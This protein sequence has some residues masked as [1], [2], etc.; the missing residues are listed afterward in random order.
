MKCFKCTSENPKGSIFCNQ[1][2]YRFRYKI[3]N[4]P[5]CSN[6]NYFPENQYCTCPDCKGLLSFVKMQT[7]DTPIEMVFVEGGSLEMGEV[8]FKNAPMEFKNA[9]VGSF[10][11]AKYLTTQALWRSVMGVNPSPIGN[12][13]NCPVTNVSWFDCVLFC[14]ALSK[15]YRLEPAYK[16]INNQAVKLVKQGKGF[17]LPTEAEWEFAAKGGVKSK[18]YIFSGSNK[19]ENVGWYK[20]NS[21]NQPHPIGELCPNELEIFDMSGNVKEWCWNEFQCY[22]NCNEIELASIT[23]GMRCSR[24]GYYNSP[25]RDCSVRVRGCGFTD[26]WCC[27]NGFRVAI[28]SI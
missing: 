28:N 4:N 17:R 21:N 19:L 15:I 27:Y 14:N 16:I 23:V 9:I 25:R 20:K 13:E 1:C 6:K 24:G 18:G 10:Y 3:C 26:E 7:F 11:I 5:T 8:V 2:G 22:S 12:D